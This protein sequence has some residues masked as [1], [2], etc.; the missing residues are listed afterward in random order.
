MTPKLSHILMGFAGCV[1]LAGLLTWTIEKAREHKGAK[2]EQA[3]QESKGEV[4]AHVGEAESIPDHS[5][6]LAKAKED[7][8]GA[9]AEVERLRKLLATKPR[10]PVSDPAGASQANDAPV[11]PDHRVEIIAAQTILVG[12]LDSQV[13]GLETALTD[14]KKRSGEYKLALE[15]SQRQA[16]AQ[17]AATKAWKDAV[18]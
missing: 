9:R 7:V 11:Q 3:A 16:M 4:K 17:E 14:E 12:R 2:Q 5:Q 10:L 1:L 18:S 15:A 6:D 13:K 8:A